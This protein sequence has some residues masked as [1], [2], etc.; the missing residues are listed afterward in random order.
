MIHAQCLQPSSELRFIGDFNP[1]VTVSNQI[2]VNFVLDYY[3]KGILKRLTIDFPF[4]NENE[5]STGICRHFFIVIFS[6]TENGCLK[7]KNVGIQ[8]KSSVTFAT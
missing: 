1:N 6:A 7:R 2:F 3:L 5:V 4:L 8:R